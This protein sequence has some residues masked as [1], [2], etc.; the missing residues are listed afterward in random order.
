[1]LR[2]DQGNVGGGSERLRSRRRGRGSSRARSSGAKQVTLPAGQQAQQGTSPRIEE[3]QAMLRACGQSGST[4]SF[5]DEA[6][7]K[8]RESCLQAGKEVRPQS[9]QPGA[10]GHT[11]AEGEENRGTVTPG[12]KRHFM[13]LQGGVGYP[14]VTNCCVSD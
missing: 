3:A 5:C 14:L 9:G 11:A 8:R 12:H 13:S 6:M 1:M 10:A 4:Q 2:D 7:K